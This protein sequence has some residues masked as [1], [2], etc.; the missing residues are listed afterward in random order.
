MISKEN[1]KIIDLTAETDDE[2]IMRYETEQGYQSNFRSIT[3]L[4]EQIMPL[5]RKNGTNELK[6]E[7]FDLLLQLN[8]T[9]RCLGGALYPSKAVPQNVRWHIKK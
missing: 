9:S 5:V 1:Q 2:F 8:R 7:L 6:L 4:C 3:L